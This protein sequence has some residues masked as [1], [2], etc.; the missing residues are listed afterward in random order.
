MNRTL[1][2]VLLVAATVHVAAA[3][4]SV[5]PPLPAPM[6]DVGGGLMF[7]ESNDHFD[8]GVG[9]FMYVGG[10][11]AP[12]IGVRGTISAWDVDTESDVLSPGSFVVSSA[13][14]SVLLHLDVEPA[15]HV[16]AG[17][18]IGGYWFDDNEDDWNDDPYHHDRMVSDT[19]DDDVGYHVLV[20]A[21]VIIAG[22][23]S[24]FVEGKYIFIDTEAWVR[25]PTGDGRTF[26][27]AHEDINLDTG[28]VTLGM[29]VKI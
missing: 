12:V 1:C 2:M 16:W 13:E 4:E 23:V 15:I 18:G 22:P 24:V 6:M 7:S 17:G 14:A 11:P 3:Q 26:T 19:I 9:G 8:S 5:Q 10:R 21:D 20:G 29:R 28:F 25:T 27:E